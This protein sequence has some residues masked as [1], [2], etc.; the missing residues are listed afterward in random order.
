MARIDDVVSESSIRQHVFAGLPSS[1]RWPMT[2]ESSKLLSS[3]EMEERFDSLATNAKEYAVFVVGLCGDLLCWNPGAE[4][5]F[6]YQSS[7]IIGHHYSR[8]FSPEDV[9]VGR[10]ESEIATA[11]SDGRSDSTCWQVRKDGTRFWCQSIVTP[12]FDE[13]KQVRSFVRVMHDLTETEAVAAMRKRADGLVEAN[14]SKE[15]F[16]ALL[17]HELRSPLSPVLNA[18]NILRQMKTNDPIIEQA[19]NIIDRQVGVMVRLVDDLLD[20]AR[21]T[22]GKLR[23]SKEQ[24]EL[25][26]VVNRAAETVRP[27]M[28]ARRHEFSVSLPTNPVWVEADPARMEQ[29]VVNLLNNA[30][31]YTETGGLV[32]MTVCREAEE[33]AIRVWDNGIG[34]A[35]DLLPQIFEL[36]TQVD[37][38]LGRSYGGL[39]IGLALARN[40]VEMHEGRLQAFSAGL[41]KGCEFTIKLPILEEPVLPESTTV[42]KPGHSSRSLRVLVVEDNVDAADSLSM[43][44]RLYGHQVE[45][46]RTGPTALEVAS[47][48]RPEVVLLD[49]GL[50]G[51]DGYQVARQLKDMPE[52]R[53]VIMCA[54]TGFTPSEADRRRQHETGFDHYYV[55][56]VALAKLLYLFDRVPLAAKGSY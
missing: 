18:L 39:G 42:L 44:L 1:E 11:E 48:F 41:G 34:I 43:L 14:R 6:G 50:P 35:P 47:V 21:I 52:F 53:D 56:P 40:L 4:R 29:V 3:Q 31:K 25:R 2:S 37:G 16:M 38:S 32:R 9:L 22:K 36:F 55:K 12:L 33:A 5:I 28:D 7:E 30:A 20:I 24:V 15:E 51:M 13:T 26:V 49:I 10:P 27:F 23:L 46:A 17:S 8:F 54:L 45:V 19:G